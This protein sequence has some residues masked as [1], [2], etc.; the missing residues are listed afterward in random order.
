M[1]MQIKAD[2]GCTQSVISDWLE[3]QRSDQWI[4]SDTV[5]LKALPETYSGLLRALTL[6]GV[7]QSVYFCYKI[8]EC[9]YIF[10]NFIGP[11]PSQ[12][13]KPQTRHRAKIATMQCRT[14]QQDDDIQCPCCGRSM[15]SANKL[16]YRPISHWVNAMY[17]NL[18][19]A[20]MLG[21]WQERVRT[22]GFMSD[23]CDGEVMR[24]IS[25]KNGA[26]TVTGD[27]R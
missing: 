12:Q 11:Q 23:V 13:K 3:L 1:L 25:T 17:S 2:T 15:S 14:Q 21:S 5:L 19:A 24:E 16:K 22:D 7:P 18:H 20:H 26:D 10:R 27:R 4:F 6:L 8:C 9:G